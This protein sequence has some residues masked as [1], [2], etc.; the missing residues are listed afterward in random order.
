M[1]ILATPFA[2]ALDTNDVLEFRIIKILPNGTIIMNRGADDYI[3]EKEHIKIKIGNK[4]I[5]RAIAV[6]SVVGISYWKLYR[7]ANPDLINTDRLYSLHPISESEIP[8][9]AQEKIQ[10]VKYND[11]LQEHQHKLMNNIAINNE[12]LISDLPPEMDAIPPDH[13]YRYMRKELTP[14]EKPEYTERTFSDGIKWDNLYYSIYASPYTIQRVNNNKSINYGLSLGTKRNEKYEL[15]YNF[16]QNVE[17]QKS[18]F[19]SDKVVNFSTSTNIV[20]DVNRITPKFSYFMLGEY[21]RVRNSSAQYGSIYPVKSQVRLGL[22]GLKYYIVE[23]GPTLSKFDISYIPIL[24][25][26]VNETIGFNPD[27][28][29]TEIQ[30][31]SKTSLRHSL[32]LRIN[33]AIDDKT[34]FY[35]TL[36]YRPRM[37]TDT[38]DIDFQDVDMNNSFTLSRQISRNVSFE[39]NNTYSY[40]IRLKRENPDYE[41]E[42]INMIHSFNLRY[43]VQ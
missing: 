15:T 33:G 3:T 5:A 18:N 36:Y 9:Y 34:F 21:Y 43:T 17:S 42:P 27:T 38:Y 10:S 7:I 23:N 19:D 30:E 4:F 13:W 1:L 29:E 28:F 24:E 22:T 16:S 40:D 14:V 25:K 6:Q 35:N 32:R 8:I 26:R 2:N 41:I 20:F 12:K 39:Y 31:V 37:D 11:Q